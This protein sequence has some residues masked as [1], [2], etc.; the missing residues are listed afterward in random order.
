MI[1]QV[2]PFILFSQLYVSVPDP[3]PGAV[4]VIGSGMLPLHMVWLAAIDP[5]ATITATVI[6]TWFDGADEQ[7]LEPIA[8][9]VVRRYQVEEVRVP[10]A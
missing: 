7:A 2:V 6:K 9:T 8:D 1:F 3:E 10:G 5:G 4:E